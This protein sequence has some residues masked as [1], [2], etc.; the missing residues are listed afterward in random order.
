[1]STVLLFIGLTGWLTILAS[2]NFDWDAP[3]KRRVPRVWLR[4]RW[5]WRRM[6]RNLKLPL[7][8]AAP[9]L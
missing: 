2:Y 9:G 7:A 5:T 8:N 3:P 4:V 1:M 6:R